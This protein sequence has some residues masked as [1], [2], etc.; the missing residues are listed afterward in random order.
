MVGA[1]VL[2]PTSTS[3]L[4]LQPAFDGQD[5]R[6]DPRTRET[7]RL[8]SSAPCRLLG[9]TAAQAALLYYP[10]FL[11][12]HRDGESHPR[13]CLN[14]R[15][16]K[17]RLAPPTGPRPI[18]AGRFA[19]A[20]LPRLPPPLASWAA[21]R[22]SPPRRSALCSAGRPQWLPNGRAAPHSVLHSKFKAGLRLLWRAAAEGGVG[23][24][25][26]DG[27]IPPLV[28][29][30][31]GVYSWLKTMARQLTCGI[32]RSQLRSTRE[33]GQR[34]NQECP[35]PASWYT[36]GPIQ[37]KA[38]EFPRSPLSAASRRQS[39]LPLWSPSENSYLQET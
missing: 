39:L 27:R 15:V 24:G 34:A 3:W 6:T 18:D 35:V 30:G 19:W 26:E 20:E 17:V 14:G 12:L 7:G 1:G 10:L 22:P 28:P 11:G 25:A 16:T 21:L 9:G 32:H 33:R 8:C 37:N 2:L 38:P 36:Y 23:G 5:T 29:V 4:L 31:S 13:G